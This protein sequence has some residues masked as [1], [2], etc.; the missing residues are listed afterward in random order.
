MAEAGQRNDGVAG[1]VVGVGVEQIDEA[2]GTA[3]AALLD[4]V[5]LIE[6]VG[7]LG[8]WAHGGHGFQ[9]RTPVVRGLGAIAAGGLKL[10]GGGEDLRIVGEFR[11][12]VTQPGFGLLHV[13]DGEG[14]AD[15]ALV[16]G[17]GGVGHVE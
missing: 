7:Q 5:S 13:L 16:V 4:E 11:E 2:G 1:A 12:G 17:G 15:H 14:G 9:G 3:R 10:R 6:L 8:R